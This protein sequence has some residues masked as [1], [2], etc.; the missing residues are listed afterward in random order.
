MSN[1]E[2]FFLKPVVC[3]VLT[4][5]YMWTCGVE[6]AVSLGTLSFFTIFSLGIEYIS[7]KKNE[8]R[9]KNGRRERN[10]RQS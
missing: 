6:I 7:Y 4:I 3:A 8:R 5:F 9:R 2:R 10:G 1:Y